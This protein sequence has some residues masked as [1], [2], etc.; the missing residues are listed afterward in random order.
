[1]WT[2]ILPLC[3]TSLELSNLSR[4][5][6]I[7]V[8]IIFIIVTLILA[9][10]SFYPIAFKIKKIKKNA[11]S[12]DLI[13][14][15]LKNPLFSF[16]I[17]SYGL[18]F[19]F[20]YLYVD[21]ISNPSGFML[22]KGLFST[23]SIDDAQNYNLFR[24]ENRDFLTSLYLIGV[25]FLNI[26]CGIFLLKYKYQRKIIFLII[27]F[28]MLF[29]GVVRLSKTDALIALFVLLVV[30]G[31]KTHELNS[32][33]YS[34]INY[35]EKIFILVV[36][37][38]LFYSTAVYR[39][40]EGVAEN[41]MIITTL[42]MKSKNAN[43]FEIILLYIYAYTS[44]NFENAALFID[45]YSGGENIGISGF[46]PIFSMFMQGGYVAD[47]LGK[48]DWNT[49]N[50]WAIANTFMAPVYAEAGFFGLV[51]FSFLYGIFINFLYWRMKSRGSL[52]YLLLYANFSFCWFFMFFAN[53]F[54]TLNFYT[55]VFFCLVLVSL[56]KFNPQKAPV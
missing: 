42:E 8:Y 1:M 56:I 22:I 5:W 15:Y 14:P 44:I 9:S 50:S 4:D 29:L 12:K 28:T 21:F 13:I 47:M 20:L 38:I 25:S 52:L 35:L 43:L 46:R 55:N 36:V 26:I 54:G 45:S 2:W 39:S 19:L 6:S 18:T 31:Y 30:N 32:N 7:Y 17:Y 24:G 34:L 11:N 37:F 16:A 53:A 3:L 41:S 23:L 33:K 40:G 49:I 10:T 51:F 27:S 48:I